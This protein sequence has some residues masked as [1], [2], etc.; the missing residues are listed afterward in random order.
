MRQV[1]T[2][3]EFW[4]MQLGQLMDEYEFLDT[5]LFKI[6]ARLDGYLKTKPGA[7]LLMTIPGIGPRITEAVLAYTDDVERL[8]DTAAGE[9]LIDG[10]RF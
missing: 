9:L 7:A 2:G 8:A 3:L 5:Q 4:Q 6:T 1:S 10:E